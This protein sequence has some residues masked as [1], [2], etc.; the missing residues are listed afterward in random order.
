M[1]AESLSD[2]V[3]GWLAL[4][5]RTVGGVS[6]ALVVL[7]TADSGPYLPRAIWPDGVPSSVGLASIV[8]AAI[9]ERRGVV[10][11]APTLRGDGERRLAHAHVA[12]P[13][14]AAGAL[15]GAIAFELASRSDD[16]LRATMRRVQWGMPWIERRLSDH[17]TAGTAANGGRLGTMLDLVATCA[18][19]RRY[20]AAATALATE[21][22]TR[23]GCERVGIGFL[24]GTYAQVEALS[25]S[26]QFSR[27]ST[28][29]ERIGAAMDEAVEQRVTLVFPEPAG[30]VP[31]IVRDQG[32]LSE[33]ASGGA[34]C[35]VPFKGAEGVCGA[36]TLE[37]PADEPFDIPTVELAEAVGALIGPLL[38]TQRRDDRPLV[39]KIVVSARST[40]GA[41]F[42]AGHLGLK[43]G[44][45][46]ALAVVALAFL[47][48]GDYRVSADTL[49][50]G[51]VQ[52]AVSAPIAGFVAE[53]K[54]RA[55]DTVHR[56]DLLARLDDR[57]LRLEQA[58]WR[59]QARQHQ[60]AYRDAMAKSNRADIQVAKAQLG[61]S[62]A[63]LALVEEKLARTRLLAPF[64]GIVVSGDL[65]QS[66][67]APVAQGDVL[68]RVAPLDG[69]RVILEVD[70]R[71]MRD[72]RVGAAGRVV[73]SGETG[74]ILP[75]VVERT[76]PVSETRDGRNYFR[77]EA[78]LLDA[79]R[80]LRPGMRGVGKIEVEPR[81]YVWIW[82]H[83][84]ID[85][86][87]LGLWSYFS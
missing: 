25:H 70:E 49:I 60:Q 35:T 26:A 18:R 53:S 63:E 22:A 10:R 39:G 37:R 76:T 84:L 34:V 78:R 59:S 75:F 19:E 12:Y 81:R 21:I 51:S 46:L 56:G 2:F 55:G 64:D 38:E 42:G 27:R 43:L 68:F 17:E 69:W 15:H 23:F 83:T 24:E 87:E 86:V 72:V 29:V 52:R 14:V 67:G 41:L 47:L 13:I 54:H 66:M 1:C 16:E 28:L 11:D 58:K 79:A 71:D 8:D 5:S 82:T 32:R 73:L 3:P 77:V 20:R 80:F 31:R 65:S 40:A 6:R 50:E 61:Q 4:M 85:W 7:G 48:R 44:C 45:A 57:D 9:A 33:F 74:A 62:E 30:G 36:I